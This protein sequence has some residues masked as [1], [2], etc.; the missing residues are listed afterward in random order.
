ALTMQ[1][2]T[3]HFGHTFGCPHYVSRINCL[4]CRDENKSV[5]SIFQSAFGNDQ[6]TENVIANGLPGVVHLHQW[7]V[8]IRGGM[9]KHFWV[10][11]IENVVHT[12][13]VFYISCKRYDLSFGPMF[14]QP[15]FCHVKGEFA[16]FEQNNA[17]WLESRELTT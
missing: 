7:H 11:G 16:C 4:M 9:K 15:L 12:A 6:G 13:L 2:L 17:P 1:R 8:L 5:Y 3:K 14:R 10:P